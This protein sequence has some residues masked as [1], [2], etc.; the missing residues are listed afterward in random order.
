[1]IQKGTTQSDR[2]FFLYFNFLYVVDSWSA[3]KQHLLAWSALIWLVAGLFEESSNY[4]RG[5]KLHL[6]GRSKYI[7]HSKNQEV[8]TGLF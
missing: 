5:P 1:M 8:V 6:V 4:P 2:Q 7:K 3:W